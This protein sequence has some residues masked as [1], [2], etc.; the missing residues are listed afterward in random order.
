MYAN[1]FVCNFSKFSLNMFLRSKSYSVF[2]IYTYMYYLHRWINMK[3]FCVI[4]DDDFFLLI[5]YK[6][7]RVKNVYRSENINNGYCLLNNQ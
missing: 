7:S 4:R 2:D 6:M 1:T 5:L 3:Q